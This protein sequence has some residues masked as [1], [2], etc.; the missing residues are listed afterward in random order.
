MKNHLPYYISVFF[1]SLLFLISCKE[2]PYEPITFG[3]I[4]G[5][6]LKDWNEEP[7]V[8]AKISTSPTLTS[9]ST[10]SIG[11]FSFEDIETGEYTFT[12][13]KDGYN[14]R[15]EK[16]IVDEENNML[17]RFY[18][19][20]KE[21]PDFGN[22]AIEMISPSEEETGLPIHIDFE[23]SYKKDNYRGSPITTSLY[24]VNTETLEERLIAENLSDSTFTATGFKFNTS[25]LWYLSVKADDSDLGATDMFRFKTQS[26]PKDLLVYC[27]E[28]D[29]SYEIFAYDSVTELSYQLTD[30]PSK[31]WFPRKAPFGDLIAFI[32]NRDN[33]N[34]IYT[35]L[36]DGT[37]LKRITQIPVTGYHNNGTG[38][39]WSPDA[40]YIIYPNNDKLIK[41]NKDGYDLQVLATAPVG[42]HFGQ[43]DWSRYGNKIVVQTV[44]EFIYDSEIYIMNT[45]G[46]GMTLLVDNLPGRTE[47]PCISFDGT[48]VYFTNDIAGLDAWDGTQLDS[49]LFKI[50]TDSTEIVQLEFAKNNGE[51]IFYPKLLHKGFGLALSIGTGSSTKRKIY[52]AKFA[53]DDGVSLAVTEIIA[54]DMPDW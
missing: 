51:N 21:A 48:E 42:R 23:W 33:E 47:S 1:L 14:N 52:E 41:V 39:A 25:Y 17:V 38:F 11:Q 20:D 44:G 37:D 34:H 3:S 49:R 13:S 30:H 8:G 54:G 36:P 32:S 45:D 12:A 22:E 53:S 15:T 6:V 46:S 27:K 4:Q 10:D 35:I 9:V 19:S 18:L 2:E 50:H 40:G 7:V 29:Q 26:I 16:V 24:S 43:C 5:T 31:D 28:I